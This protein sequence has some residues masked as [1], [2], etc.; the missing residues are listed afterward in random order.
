MV[1]AASSNSRPNPADQFQTHGYIV[2][3]ESDLALRDL[4]AAMDAI[5]MLCE[6]RKD[7]VPEMSPQMWGGLFRTLARQA[8]AI[9]NGAAFTHD[10]TARARH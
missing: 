5:A 9:H 3:E 10:A 2:S 6:D 8:K 4:G 1:R 7:D